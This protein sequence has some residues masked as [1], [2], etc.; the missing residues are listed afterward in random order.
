MTKPPNLCPNCRVLFTPGPVGPSGPRESLLCP[1]CSASS[2]HRGVALALNTLLAQYETTHAPPLPLA[3]YEI[4]LSPL[5]PYLRRRFRTF[6]CSELTPRPG[7]V[8]QDLEHLTFEDAR[9]D[10]VICSD[11]LEHVRLYLVALSEIARVLKPGGHLI[12]TVP[13]T[14]AAGHARYCQI[15]DPAHPEL[16]AWSPDAPRHIDPLDPAGCPVYR[17]YHWELLRIE[18]AFFRLAAHLD[19]GEHPTYAVHRA[20]T[21]IATRGPAPEVPPAGREAVHIPTTLQET[22]P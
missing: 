3:L 12:L 19:P 2:R 17:E 1:V 16:D 10:F 21:I 4:G 14:S 15:T 18:L 13:L 20:P 6:V 7:A 9:F 22:T 5:T 11:V 8:V